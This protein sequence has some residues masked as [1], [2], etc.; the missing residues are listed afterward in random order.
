MRESDAFNHQAT[1]Q[2]PE[3][4][5]NRE[6][7]KIPSLELK[8]KLNKYNQVDLGRKTG[9]KGCFPGLQPHHCH[10]WVGEELS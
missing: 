7:S 2:P 5:S 4:F 1:C 6:K 8:K 9:Q 10:L 3:L